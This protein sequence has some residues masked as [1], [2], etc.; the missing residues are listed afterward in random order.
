MHVFCGR[1]IGENGFGQAIQCF[2]CYQTS[3]IG[4]AAYLTK[5]LD[6]ENEEAPCSSNASQSSK[7]RAQSVNS[8]A[9]RRKVI[10]WLL[11][12]EK[13]DGMDGIFAKAVD[14]FPRIFNSAPRSA[15]LQ[16][17]I[18]WWRKRER[19]IETKRD[20]LVISAR[21]GGGRRRSSKKLVG[22]RGRP[23]SPWVEWLYPLSKADFV[24]QKVTV[25]GVSMTRSTY[26][27]QNHLDVGSN[28]YG[29]PPNCTQDAI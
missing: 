19:I 7:R 5:T 4:T 20:Q 8:I 15:N 25:H 24:A 14:R 26:H 28:L 12:Y 16:K 13:T 21:R 10:R 22:G 17:V 23:T 1:A 11:A 27:Q 18:D 9:N 2:Q 6:N 29:G 3:S